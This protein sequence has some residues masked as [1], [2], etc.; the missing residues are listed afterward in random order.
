M[1]AGALP[2]FPKS[3]VAMLGKVLATVLHG[4]LP[5]AEASKALEA[6]PELAQLLKYLSGK[7]IRAEG[8]LVSFGS[9]N[10]FGVVTIEN[11]AGGDIYRFEIHVNLPIGP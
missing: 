8:A 10:Q 11:A 2:E 6:V 4:S 3:A 7:T 1:L 9:S 5:S